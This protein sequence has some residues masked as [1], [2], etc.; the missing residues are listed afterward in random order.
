MPDITGRLTP[1]RGRRNRY[2]IGEESGDIFEEDDEFD[3][4]TLTVEVHSDAEAM[5]MVETLAGSTGWYIIDSAPRDGSQVDLLC[6]AI[7]DDGTGFEP[8]R[9]VRF[10]AC[11]WG[12]ET[13]QQGGIWIDERNNLRPGFWRRVP[14]LPFSLRDEWPEC[15][16]C[17]DYGPFLLTPLGA[18]RLCPHCLREV[19][20]ELRDI[21]EGIDGY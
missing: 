19:E 14:E 2:R 9:H 5:R 3:G 12:G 13:W 21:A 1:H 18:E 10:T 16:R 8:R 15:T 17:H 6:E 7:R 4:M 11:H 20:D